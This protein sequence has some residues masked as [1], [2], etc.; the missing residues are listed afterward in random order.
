MRAVSYDTGAANV[1][2]PTFS[3]SPNRTGQLVGAYLMQY[4]NVSFDNV[5]AMDNSIG[6]PVSGNGLQHPYVSTHSKTDSTSPV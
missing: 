2:P 5:I 6:R 3:D 4:H 1:K